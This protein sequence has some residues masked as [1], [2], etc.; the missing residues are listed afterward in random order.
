MAKSEEARSLLKELQATIVELNNKN[1]QKVISP[2]MNCSLRVLEK[3]P[4]LFSD[5]FDE[6]LDA[7]IWLMENGNVSSVITAT[8][9]VCSL[10]QWYDNH[11]IFFLKIMKILSVTT[12]LQIH[13]IV[14]LHSQTDT[15]VIRLKSQVS[16]VM[17]KV[18]SVRCL[19]AAKVLFPIK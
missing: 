19:H 8:R 9:C 14:F 5:C 2:P 16:M 3:V 6:I 7:L 13:V 15:E 11:T 4:C 12:I 1:C 18:D 10:Y 17:N